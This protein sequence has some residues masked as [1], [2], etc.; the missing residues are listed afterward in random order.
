MVKLMDK[1]ERQLKEDARRIR[2]ELSPTLQERIRASLEATHPAE[3]SPRPA[4]VPGMKLWWASSLTGLAIAALVIVLANWKVPVEPLE[5]AISTPPLTS[6]TPQGIFPISAET[7]EWT[8][9]LEEELRNLQSDLEKA[10]ENV[11]RDLKS[12]F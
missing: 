4:Q 5:D 8:A 9:P 3:Q 6:R 2:A 10:R 1:F 11:E 12:S 7:A